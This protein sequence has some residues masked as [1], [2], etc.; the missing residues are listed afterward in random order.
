MSFK[1]VDG[2]SK[3]YPFPCASSSG[4]NAGEVCV[5]DVTNN[6]IKVAT[7]SLLAEDLACVPIADA[8]TAGGLVQ[9][10][11]IKLMGNL[12]E[13]DCTNNTNADQLCQRSLLTDAATVANTT[14]EQAV[15]E[16]TVIPIQNVGAAANK[17]QRGF[18]A[19]QPAVS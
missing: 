5:W 17:K 18:F 11:P 14:T 8:P 6:V 19:Y 9:A 10:I 3:A 12:W 16:V 1:C 4:I 2:D 7:A 15:D 13:W